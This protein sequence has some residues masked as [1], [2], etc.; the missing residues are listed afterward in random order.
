L[1]AAIK[2]YYCCY[3]YS[4]HQIGL[5]TN[6][7]SRTRLPRRAA[8]AAA[9]YN[10]WRAGVSLINVSLTIDEWKT[11]GSLAKF[12]SIFKSATAVL[13]GSQYSTV[14]LVLLFRSEICEAL[15]DDDL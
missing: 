5:K 7:R 13:S 2:D 3:Y 6:C 15:A 12:L 14:S 8:A 11:I 4:W 10:A 9:H 1:S